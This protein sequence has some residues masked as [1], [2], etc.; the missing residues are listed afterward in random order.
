MRWQAAGEMKRLAALFLLGALFFLAAGA[1]ADEAGMR[2][3]VDELRRQELGVI[4]QIDALD[5]ESQKFKSRRQDLQEELDSLAEQKRADQLRVV[6]LSARLAAIEKRLARRLKA[7]YAHQQ[8]GLGLLVLDA[9]SLGEALLV[10]QLLGRVVGFDLQLVKDYNE[11]KRRVAEAKRR[12]LVR[13]Q[14]IERLTSEL[15]GAEAGLE[16][17]RRERAALL[18]WLD[19]QKQAFEQALAELRQAATALDQEMA[20]LEAGGVGAGVGWMGQQKGR[21][22]W[23]V[24]GR[25][26][27]LTDQG[28]QGIL[29]L[30]P[31][32]A[33]VK[34][35]GSG[36]VAYAGWVKGYGQVV[37]IDHGAR[38]YTL[39]GHL[40]ERTVGISQEVMAGQKIGRVGRSGLSQ[41]GLYFEI[42]HKDQALD[43]L[44]WLAGTEP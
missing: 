41:A 40:E 32:G 28:R 33:P 24:R 22:P 18:L 16:N 42:R 10:R 1:R 26:Q 7:L 8:G 14:E 35:V 13:A 43:P 5:R 3:S 6:E 15:A 30:A 38:Y 25:P 23:P 44:P 36:K 11:S 39:S 37:I 29:I 27:R 20:D 9:S 12:R 34:A 4:A 21:L 31:E 17:Q 2:E 19:E